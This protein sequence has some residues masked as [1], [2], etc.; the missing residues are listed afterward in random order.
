MNDESELVYLGRF[1]HQVKVNGYRIELGEIQAELEKQAGV[2][3]AV[4][5]VH[6]EQLIAYVKKQDWPSK[7]NQRR[8]QK[9]L[10]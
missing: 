2:S 8:R 7:R 10:V 9:K 1:D 3:G 6:E 5:M 4:A